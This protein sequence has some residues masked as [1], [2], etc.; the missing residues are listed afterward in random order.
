MTDASD[1]EGWSVGPDGSLIRGGGLGYPSLGVSPP[2]AQGSPIDARAAYNLPGLPQKQASLLGNTSMSV[3]DWLTRLGA[4][5]NP[6]QPTPLNQGEDQV[7]K[8]FIPP[9]NTT[10]GTMQWPQSTGFVQFPTGHPLSSYRPEDDPRFTAPNPYGTGMPRPPARPAAAPTNTP[11]PPSR[12]APAAAAAA[13]PAPANINLGYGAPLMNRA[14]APAGMTNQVGPVTGNARGG[15]GPVGMGMPDLSGWFN[16]SNPANVPAP[17]ATPV[18][19]PAPPAA[20]IKGALS[21]APWFMGPFQNKSPFG[22]NLPIGL[23]SGY[24]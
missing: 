18:N 6:L 5:I 7:L 10:P 3:M 13:P 8:K 22:P 12:P 4:K 16:R 2:A 9:T 19:S 21:N 14:N 17:N 15:G 24:Q 1:S 11:L 23:H 20:P